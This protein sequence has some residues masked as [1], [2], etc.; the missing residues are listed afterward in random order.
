[1]RGEE[2]RSQAVGFSVPMKGDARENQPFTSVAFGPVTD[3]SREFSGKL[4][5]CHYADRF[6]AA[7]AR[8]RMSASVSTSCTRACASR[9]SC[10]D[11]GSNSA[12][13]SLGNSRWIFIGCCRE[14]PQS[15]AELLRGQK[16]HRTFFLLCGFK[17]AFRQS[18][19]A[20][21]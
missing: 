18:A 2:R 8:S 6:C 11:S 21:D 3:K 5:P 12:C 20:N 4:C 1:M 7:S 10:S 9:R 15:Q 14:R 16:E 13:Q 17:F 19:L